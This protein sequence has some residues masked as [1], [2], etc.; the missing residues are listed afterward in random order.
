MVLQLPESPQQ[1]KMRLELRNGHEGLFRNLS[2]HRKADLLEIVGGWCGLVPRVARGRTRL[3]FAV[4][5][6]GGTLGVGGQFTV[7]DYEVGTNRGAT[8]H[9][10]S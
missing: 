6:R 7:H 4:P 2:P 3:M 1:S 9:L 8:A 5:R 10:L